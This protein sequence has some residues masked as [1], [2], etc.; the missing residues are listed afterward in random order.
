MSSTEDCLP[1]ISAL[2][3]CILECF[4]AEE[5]PASSHLPAAGGTPHI[6]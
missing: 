6:N 2:G 5:S 4:R 1:G 3:K